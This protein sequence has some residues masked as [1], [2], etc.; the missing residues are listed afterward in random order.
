[1]KTTRNYAML[2]ASLF[3]FSTSWAQ[4]DAGLK[5]QLTAYQ[6]QLIER[7]FDAATNQLH[8]TVFQVMPATRWVDAQQSKV[9]EDMAMR[10]TSF[11]DLQS[12]EMITDNGQDYLHLTALEYLELSV[13][14]ENI[15]KDQVMMKDII[16][17]F[18]KTY[19]SDNVK[20]LNEKTIFLQRD[21]Q[22]IA[23]KATEASEWQL[24]DFPD[25]NLDW[26]YGIV[27]PAVWQAFFGDRTLSDQL[28]YQQALPQVAGRYFQLLKAKSYEQ[29]P[30]VIIAQE[31]ATAPFLQAYKSFD[32]EETM[33]V[34]QGYKVG[35]IQQQAIAEGK[36][37]TAFSLQVIMDI[38]MKAEEPAEEKVLL[39]KAQLEKMYP[40][41]VSYSEE[42]AAFTINTY[43]SVMAAADQHKNNWLL[44]PEDPLN[45]LSI[46][47]NISK[48]LQQAV[49]F[50]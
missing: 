49:G 28:P 30:A 38:K 50:D 31:K 20:L 42:N 23:V 9:N 17:G 47:Q 36:R 26:A 18:A 32:T 21:H 4:M 27:P 13:E 43:L 6:Q 48:E 29:V 35:N 3:F 15:S 40:D 2:L 19:G 33:L 41:A 5:E 1:M 24:I 7:S 39:M 45:G 14:Q 8:P 46:R 11:R 10:T 37:Y 34:F 22:F 16:A 12:S 44:L 25:A